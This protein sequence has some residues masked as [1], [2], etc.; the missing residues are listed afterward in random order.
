M[1][2]DEE[3]YVWLIQLP[4]NGHVPAGW[5]RC[6]SAE[7]SARAARFY[8]ERDRARFTV[9]HAAL[10]D[11]LSRYTG[12]NAAAIVI[13]TA[14]KGKPYLADHPGLRFNLSHS[15]S[16]ALVGV[17]RGREVGVD[18]E[19]IRRER[20]TGGI[21]ER[22]F[23]PAEVWEL[24]ETPEDRRVAAFFACWSRKEAYIKARGEGLRIPLTSFEVSLDERAVLRK[25]EDRERWSMCS[26]KAPAGY[27]AALV[28]E[29]SGWRVKQFAWPGPPE[30]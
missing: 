24:M 9:A 27:A 6:L 29:G 8:F 4:D 17:A 15:G 12:E 20:S 11:I 10:R 16:W 28:A 21:A 2:D 1:P 25:A 30:T 3:I 18:I 14:E 22:F 7:E 19:C 13:R 5:A 26:L 23:A